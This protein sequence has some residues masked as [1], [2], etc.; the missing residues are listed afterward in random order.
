[1]DEI[2]DHFAVDVRRH[3]G[4]G[5][6]A[7]VPV[8]DGPRAVEEVAD[9]AHSPAEGGFALPKGGVAV[10]GLDPD[11]LPEEQ[12]DQV[13]AA[14]DLRGQGHFPDDGLV[15]FN[16]LPAGFFRGGLDVLR[17]HGAGALH[18]DEGALQVSAQEPGPGRALLLPLHDGADDGEGIPHLLRGGGVGGGQDGSHPGLCQVREPGFH[19]L[20]R[21]GHDVEAAAAV[22]VGVN[23]AG[24]HDVRGV[25]RGPAGGDA[26]NAA[27]PDV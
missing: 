25:V 16:Q 26:G 1:M 20:H 11:A 9:G 12:I 18:A 10:P 15:A 27:V 17:F 5:E 24:G 4:G 8:A 7:G 19:A 22:E 23:E 3:Q 13:P 2:G 21:G 6:E 14:G